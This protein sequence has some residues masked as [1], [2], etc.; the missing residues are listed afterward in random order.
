MARELASFPQTALR[1]DRRSVYAALGLPLDKALASEFEIGMTTLASGEAASGAAA[2]SK[3]AGRGGAS[4]AKTT[5]RRV[6]RAAGN[7][8]P[9]RG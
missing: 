8:K 7:R 5:R 4:I 2:F 9:R 6:K 3:G 1:N